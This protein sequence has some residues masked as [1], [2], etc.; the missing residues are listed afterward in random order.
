M[1]GVPVHITGGRIPR[2]R[3]VARFLRD[4]IHVLKYRRLPL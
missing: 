3:R 1:K 4:L 2:R